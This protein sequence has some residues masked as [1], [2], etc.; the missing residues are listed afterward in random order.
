MLKLNL[1]ACSYGNLFA[2][3]LYNGSTQLGSCECKIIPATDDIKNKYTRETIFFYML[4]KIIKNIEQRD[5]RGDPSNWGNCRLYV[6]TMLTDEAWKRVMIQ[7]CNDT[8]RFLQPYFCKL[9]VLCRSGY[10]D[11]YLRDMVLNL[12]KEAERLSKTGEYYDFAMDSKPQI[13]PFDGA[14]SDLYS[15]YK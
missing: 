1:Y 4:E 14:D 11:H 10:G 3:Q 5:L 9:Q 8:E 13:N 2:Y 6:F 7:P 12:R 15:V